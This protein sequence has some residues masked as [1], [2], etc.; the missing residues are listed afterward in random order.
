[1]R[2]LKENTPDAFLPKFAQK[3]PPSS[4]AG[5]SSSLFYRFSSVSLR[6][7]PALPA[8]SSARRMRRNDA[9]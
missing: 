7:L 3:A 8:K 1:M 2:T 6:R 9:P 4:A 5:L